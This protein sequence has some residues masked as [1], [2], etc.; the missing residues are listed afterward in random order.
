MRD[1]LHEVVK[2]LWSSGACSA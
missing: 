2:G 1:T